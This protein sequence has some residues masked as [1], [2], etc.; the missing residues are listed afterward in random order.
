MSA[1]PYELRAR[2]LQQAEGIL[3]NRYH[4][5]NDRTRDT[6]HMKL[7]QDPNFDFTTITYPTMPTT[8]DIIVEAEKLYKFVQTK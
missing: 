6:V 4:T 7:K 3:M 8:E 5:E 2:L 1:T